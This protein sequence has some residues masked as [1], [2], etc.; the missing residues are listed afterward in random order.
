LRS[1]KNWD[2]VCLSE[3]LYG[4][5]QILDTF[6]VLPEI[7]F[8]STR[9]RGSRQD[10]SVTNEHGDI[11]AV[12]ACVKVQCDSWILIDVTQLS[13]GFFA[14]DQNRFAVSVEP[15][16]PRLGR[17]IVI[18]RGEPDDLLLSQA[19]IDVAA[20]SAGEVQHGPS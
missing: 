5:V 7:S 16:G 8:D 3:P 14:E 1:H 10:F 2:G 6:A 18:D 13:L 20:K 15:D 12:F 9:I 17:I 11:A 19:M 4:H